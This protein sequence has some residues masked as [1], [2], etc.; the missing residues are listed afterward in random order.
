MTAFDD[1]TAVAATGPGRFTAVGDPD[2]SAPNGPNGGYLAATILR[3]MEAT[4]GDASRPARSITL[5]YL[6]PPKPAE[7]QIDVAVERSGRTLSTLSARLAQEGRLCVLATAAFAGAFPPSPVRLATAMPVVPPPDAVEPYPTHAGLPPIARRLIL[8]G[9]IGAPPFSGADEALTGG[10]MSLHE[11]QPVDAPLLALYA[12]GWL[13]ASF[14]ALTEPAFAPTID[15]TVHFRDPAAAAA[16]APDQ[17]VLGVFRTRWSADG[18]I[19][20]DGELWSPDGVL[21]AHSR[22]LALLAPLGDR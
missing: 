20:E 11:P 21:L 5:H 15:L 14:T 16:L 2:W 17:P 19:D 8:R 3:A 4:L 9:A 18:L 6:R 7:M 10:W 1:A 13:P 12:D 22:Q